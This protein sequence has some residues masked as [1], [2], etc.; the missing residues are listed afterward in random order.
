MSEQP[1]TQDLF[2][3]KGHAGA[4]DGPD[5]PAKP[6]APDLFAPNGDDPPKDV[7]SAKAK[8]L[9]DDGGNADDPAAAASLSSIQLKR[10]S[11]LAAALAQDKDWASAPADRVPTQDAQGAQP[12]NSSSVHGPYLALL[13]IICFAIGIWFT[14]SSSNRADRVNVQ[15]DEAAVSAMPADQGDTSDTPSPGNT[16]VESAAGQQAA[17]SPT[18]QEADAAGET[19][20]LPKFDLIRIEP[21]GEAVIAGRADPETELILLDNGEPIGKVTADLAGEWAFIPA[22]P[23]APGD[24]EFSLVIVTS[25]GTVAVPGVGKLDKGSSL[26][27]PETGGNPVINAKGV[28]RP[29]PEEPSSAGAASAGGAAGSYSVQLSSTTSWKG[30]EQEWLKLQRSFPKLLGDKTL[31]VH[32]AELKQRGTW[33]RVRTGDFEELATA[34]KFCSALRAKRQDCLVIKR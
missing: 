21:N 33:Y 32:K 22:T 30:A 23:L 28:S 7:K 29:G 13:A 8:R 14:I 19:E 26:Q 12:L 16:P 6:P 17:S 20:R 27:P 24:H 10:G 18:G 25:E 31:V 4:G 5:L 15:A 3:R 9:P 34:R 1:V 11:G 2:A